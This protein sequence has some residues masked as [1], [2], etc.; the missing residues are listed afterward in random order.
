MR[1]TCA[2]VSGCVCVW[3]EAAVSGDS[4]VWGTCVSEGWICAVA[5]T[6]CHEKGTVK[7]RAT[8]K[9][10]TH[11]HEAWT[12]VY[13]ERDLWRRR[14][15]GDRDRVRWRGRSRRVSFSRSRS[16][17]LGFGLSSVFAGFSG[18]A[19]LGTSDTESSFASFAS[20]LDGKVREC[21]EA[22][23]GFLHPRRNVTTET[24]AFL[25]SYLVEEASWIRG[26]GL[27]LSDWSGSGWG[28][29]LWLGGLG[30]GRAG[31]LGLRRGER[32]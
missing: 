24:G 23:P 11:T 27:E 14:G 4:C 21:S 18:D 13:L 9:T 29:G 1:C 32:E 20:S 19:S 7:P 15:R 17:S 10:P 28:S 22:S 16:L 3:R 26:S 25:H 12:W 6:T 8:R 31:G 30:R 5:S 2:Q